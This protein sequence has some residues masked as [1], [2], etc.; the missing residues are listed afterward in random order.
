MN[1][2]PHS[3][4]LIL[5]ALN[6]EEL[7]KETIDVYNKKLSK[8]FQRYEIIVVDDG[9]KDK[10]SQIIKRLLK[11]NS[12][13]KVITHEKNLGVGR[14]ILDGFRAASME[15]V[16]TNSADRPFNLEDLMRG[17]EFFESS[18]AIVVSR[19]NRSANPFFR[20]LTSKVSYYLVKTFFRVPISDFHFVQI[21]RRSVLSSI[22]VISEDTFAPAELLIK[23]YKKGYRF[24]E[25]KAVFHRRTKGQSKYNNPIRYLKYLRELLK[26]W[27]RLHKEKTETIVITASMKRKRIFI[28]GGAGFIG[29]ALCRKMQQ[30]NEILV[31]DN[32]RRNTLQYFKQNGI[33]KN[34]QVVQGDIMD[35]GLLRGSVSYFKPDMFLHLAA[36]AGVTDYYKQ[37]VKTMEVNA[38]GTYNVL[39]AIKNFNLEMF[40]YFSTSEVY[41][42]TIFGAKEDGDT[43]QG[44]IK[45]VRWVYG[46]S[47][48][49]GEG[50]AF[51]YSQE[52]K[53]PIISIRPFNIYGPG[54]V[55]EGAIQIFIRKSL[56]NEMIEVTG[57]G[58]QI[59]AW[60]YID[61]LVEGVMLVLKNKQAIGEIFNIGNPGGA[62]TILNLAKMIIAESNSRSQIKLV[63]HLGVD[64]DLRVPSIKKA[65]ELLGFS[66][67]VELKEGIQRSI[68]WYK[69]I[70]L[71]EP[72]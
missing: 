63:P 48:L 38:V 68:K 50:L 45:Q 62:I 35:S 36:M 57:D 2:I 11:K 49:A 27:I 21:Y 9:S 56:A 26:F 70:K 29:T 40:V 7:I 8:L 12:H 47:K 10:T 32:F 24:S 46:I 67:K 69:G 71:T 44:E 66:P 20:K 61:D 1:K 13:L 25:F 72:Y 55:G 19:F 15:F 58:N 30:D 18:D 52:Y 31:F 16:M 22:E 43:I 4:S 64:I 23:L 53:I 39:Q 5:P 41:G 33:Y 60:C 6:E 17:K 37:P 14:A 51:A 54:Q 59:R 42:P 28:T 34:I 65:E 3:L